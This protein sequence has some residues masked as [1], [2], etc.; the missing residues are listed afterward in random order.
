MGMA[1]RWKGL[2]W[3]FV[4]FESEAF[5]A[6]RTGG[7]L[8]EGVE[9]AGIGAGVVSDAVLEDGGIEREQKVVHP[10]N[11]DA[12]AGFLDELALLCVDDLSGEVEASMLIVEERLFA[13]PKLVAA[14]VPAGEVVGVEGIAVAG[15]F[16]DDI[17]VGRA[18]AEHEI[19]ELADAVGEASDFAAPTAGGGPAWNNGL[20]DYW[21]G[22]WGEG[23]VLWR[24]CVVHGFVYVRSKRLFFWHIFSM[25]L[26]L[27]CTGLYKWEKCQN[28]RESVVRGCC[29]A[30]SWAKSTVSKKCQF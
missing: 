24:G 14:G 20:L 1:G 23:L 29:G 21:I 30:G 11:G 2:V 16:L 6:D 28:F 5:E 12:E 13:E 15:K 25:G 8:R 10:E 22:A 9:D 18:V 17:G 19:E 7:E 26:W 3:F 27:N 4:L